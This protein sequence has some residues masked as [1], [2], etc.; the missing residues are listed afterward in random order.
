MQRKPMKQ[1]NLIAVHR[2]KTT[3]LRGSMRLRGY[4][5]ILW[6]IF[7][8]GMRWSQVLVRMHFQR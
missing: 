4:M 2:V 8:R 5:S 6:E 3:F 7:H 1:L